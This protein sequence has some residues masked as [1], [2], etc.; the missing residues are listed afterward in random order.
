M[1]DNRIADNPAQAEL[2]SN[3]R[4]PRVA[5]SRPDEFKNAK[6]AMIHGW[7]GVVF[8]QAVFGAAVFLVSMIPAI[9]STGFSDP[10]ALFTLVFVLILGMV[11]LFLAGGFLGA[12]WSTIVIAV[13]G[14]LDYS[15][16]ESISPRMAVRFFGAT[17]GL[18][19]TCWIFLGILSYNPVGDVL[20]FFSILIFGAM[21]FGQVGGLWWAAYHDAWRLPKRQIGT[22]IDDEDTIRFGIRH[23]LLLMIVCSVVF[24]GDAVFAN[25]FGLHAPMVIFGVY[26]FGML[27]LIGSDQ[28]MTRWGREARA[29]KRLRKK[30]RAE[31]LRQAEEKAQSDSESDRIAT[32]SESN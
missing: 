31:K 11:G 7:T 2:R 13:I 12:F 6:W 16:G 23:I 26:V 8:S 3:I 21:A 30:E 24:T 28:T 15:L 19:A 29:E 14:G 18:L 5:V 32:A 20:A 27:V 25:R 22:G 17:T 4:S 9:V 10:V 1:E